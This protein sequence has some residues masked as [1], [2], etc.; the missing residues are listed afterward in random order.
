M[1]REILEKN[2]DARLKVYAVWFD[3]LGSDDRSAWDPGLLTDSRVLQFWDEDREVGKWFPKQEE[4]AKLTFGPLAWDIYF[5]YGPDAQ[6][7]A[8]PWPLIVS[9]HTIISER[10]NLREN[11]QKILS[12]S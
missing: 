4:Y 7:E 5:L 11:L 1:Q 9:G 10:N 12:E 6:W 3:V 8:V 2:P